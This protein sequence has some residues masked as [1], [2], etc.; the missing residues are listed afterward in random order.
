MDVSGQ[1][2]SPDQRSRIQNESMLI[3]DTVHRENYDGVLFTPCI[4]RITL[5]YV[6]HNYLYACTCTYVLFL[7]D[8]SDT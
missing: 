7:Y 6:L 5:V 1:A 2:V 3:M 4:V 8:C